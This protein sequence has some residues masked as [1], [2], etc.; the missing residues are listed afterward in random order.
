MS[1]LKS[2]TI[3]VN[4]FKYEEQMCA[5]V[6]V[7]DVNGNMWFSGKTIVE[8]LRN[9]SKNTERVVNQLDQC[10]KKVL[11]EIIDEFEVREQ[12][13]M[14][15][16]TRSIMINL[17]GVKMMIDK[18]T[19]ATEVKKQWINEKLAMIINGDLRKNH[20]NKTMTLLDNTETVSNTEEEIVPNKLQLKQMNF[21]GKPFEFLV[22]YDENKELWMYGRPIAEYLEYSNA[23]KAIS[24]LNPLYTR[25]YD[26]FVSELTCSSQSGTFNLIPEN[27]IKTS[28][29]INQAGLF[30][31][32]TKS[33]MPKAKEFQQW[34][35]CEIVPK[36][37]TKSTNQAT[38]L[39]ILNNNEEEILPNKDTTTVAILNNNEEEILPNKLQLKQINFGDTTF[40]FVV[41]YDT[42][43][44]LWM[45]GKP[46]AEYLEYRNPYDAISN[47]NSLYT[48]KY[49][50]FSNEAKILG[51]NDSLNLKSQNIISSSVFINQAGLFELMNK[52]TM[53]RAK[54]FQHWVNS[55]VL[56]K[57]T[58]NKVYNMCE[59]PI[60]QQQQIESVN[61]LVNQS[62]QQQQNQ[63][64]LD[65]AAL[66]IELLQTKLYAA[67]REIELKD[68]SRKREDESRKREA[69]LQEKHQIEVR[70]SSLMLEK[71]R[72]RVEQSTLQQNKF[73][74][75]FSVDQHTKLN[76]FRNMF[77]THASEV[78]KDIG[79]YPVL[80][81]YMIHKD[82]LPDKYNHLYG[83]TCSRVQK[84][85]S[86]KKAK[87]NEYEQIY[88]TESPN[89]INAW[90]CVKDRLVTL[91]Q[92]IVDNNKTILNVEESSPE[93]ICIF[94]CNTIYC[95]L[96]KNDMINLLNK[97]SYGFKQDQPILS[98]ILKSNTIY[99]QGLGQGDTS[100][101]SEDY[102]DDLDDDH[103]IAIE[104]V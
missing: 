33:T 59:A 103:M 73:L 26:D 32:M 82:Y 35:K 27:I 88:L 98:N 1:T 80:E 15:L 45:Y 4:C 64:P 69:E 61:L 6:Y 10:Y 50:N 96:N 81:V 104:Y 76:L 23:G 21:G 93:I 31:L 100:N 63:Q 56:P 67:Q 97:R 83:Y 14:C 91:K 22:I 38:T 72:Q 48:R 8:M 16:K 71:A 20:Q 99:R 39:S 85:Q 18:D 29:F 30:E 84:K 46:I 40:E 25:K 75:R 51:Y 41:I 9:I 102:D 74:K 92:S 44:D 11:Q 86:G 78:P 52:S 87:L 53:P 7:F 54:E 34:I 62:I 12:L 43:M 70:N 101:E 65:N 24:T 89:A 36:L 95:S 57:L 77:T 19:V 5:F 17:E 66:Q 60:E 28:V 94:K 90:R 13:P 37:V 55:D 3:K 49:N 42:N 68:E 47:V 58:K 79:T 2:M